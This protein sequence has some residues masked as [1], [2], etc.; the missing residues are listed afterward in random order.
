MDNV[1][2]ETSVRRSSAERYYKPGHH[3]SLLRLSL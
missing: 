1:V 3:E 2:C